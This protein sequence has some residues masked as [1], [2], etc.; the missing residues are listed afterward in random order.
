MKRLISAMLIVLT[1]FII[2]VHA[3]ANIQTYNEAEKYITTTS[4]LNLRKNP[5]TSSESLKKLPTGTVLD[6]T[7]ISDGWGKVTYQEYE[8]WISMQYAVPFDDT[9][10]RFSDYKVKWDVIDISKWQNDI[11]WDKIAQSD[12][13]A[14]IIRIGFRGTSTKK[15]HIDDMFF[16]HYEGAKKAG[17]HVGCYFYSAA[18]TEAEAVEEA[19]FI[20]ETIKNNNLSFDMPVYIDMEDTVVE[21]TGQTMIFRMTKAYLDK[22]DE[23]NIFS[24]VYC[25]SWWAET[26]YSDSL[27]PRHA[28]WIAEWKDKCSYNGGYGMWQYTE[29]GKIDGI[30]NSYTDLNKCYI[31]YPQLIENYGYNKNEEETEP[32]IPEITSSEI[33]SENESI[34]M[35]EENPVF[36]S[37]D[38][39][40]D[41][42]ITASDARLV[43][44]HSSEMEELTDEQLSLSDMNSDSVIT[45]SDAR[46]I[47]RISAGLI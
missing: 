47:L 14:V 40:M 18:T 38:V 33:Y 34:T 39:N 3:F 6:V 7:E 43:L 21:S 9:K 16:E 29:K 8:G 20:I 25:G 28:L 19:E 15:I 24:G 17:L 4:N 31:N 35:P 1:V 10:L 22:M 44:R 5:T 30:N 42:S 23:E 32:V 26:F 13:Q 46:Q 41:G 37:G 12:I 11:D 45:A 36:K 2:S 27:F